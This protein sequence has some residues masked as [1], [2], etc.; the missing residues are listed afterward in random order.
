MGRVVLSWSS[1]LTDTLNNRDIDSGQQLNNSQDLKVGAS[2]VNCSF[3]S[4]CT[5][6]GSLVMHLYCF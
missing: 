2:E 4:E 6:T 5:T 1:S 3:V